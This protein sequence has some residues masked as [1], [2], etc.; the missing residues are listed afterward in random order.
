MDDA[1]PPEKPINLIKID[2]EGHEYEALCGA[3]QLIKR[4][5]P[6]IIFEC[7]PSASPEK[8]E[9]LLRDFG[10]SISI[11]DPVVRSR[12][13]V[14]IFLFP[15]RQNTGTTLRP[16]RIPVSRR[17]RLE[18]RKS[19]PAIAEIPPTS[20]SSVSLIQPTAGARAS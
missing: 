20:H 13:N 19:G 17:T 15:T 4:W 18:I 7:L 8:L 5:S 2:V 6:R 11:L 14:S 1:I 12:S 3:E 16:H 10:Y 9:S